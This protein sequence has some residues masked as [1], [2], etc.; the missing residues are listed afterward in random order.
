MLP[1]VWNLRARR[2]FKPIWRCFV[3]GK[4]RFGFRLIEYTVLR[5]HIHLIAE[6]ED[7]RALARG[8]QGLMIRIAKALNAVMGRR[9]KVFADRFHARPLRT[10]AEVKNALLYVLDNARRHDSEGTFRA[11][12]RAH[13]LGAGFTFQADDCSSSGFFGWWQRKYPPQE[14]PQY[15]V[16]PPATW[17]LRVGWKRSPRNPRNP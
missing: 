5:N 16:A 17:L 15:P 8:M 7:S 9:G 4:E 3:A 10:P 11:A 13:R 2:C 1:H 12:T 14:A 6:V